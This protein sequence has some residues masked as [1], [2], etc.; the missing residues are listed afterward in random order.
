[1]ARS[2]RAETLSEGGLTQG[3]RALAGGFDELIDATG[4]LRPHWE[5]LLDELAALSPATRSLRTE[6]LN[7]RVRETGITHDPFADPSSTAQPWRIDLVPL[8]VAPGEWRQLERA[9]IQ[10]ARLFQGI[11]ADL[12]GPQRLLASGAIPHQLVFSDPSFLRPCHGIKPTGG[13]IQFFASD[14]ARGPDGRWRIID[15][16]TETP[17]RHRLRASPTA[18]CTPTLPATF[19]APATPCAWRRSSSSCRA[20]WPGAPIAPTRPLP[21]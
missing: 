17:G 21:C 16:H 5:P 1:M 14:L 8:V 6:Q 3:Y 20:H 2:A 4:S 19:S 11:L 18:W 7:A 13:H 10:R 12:Y 9:L 15:T